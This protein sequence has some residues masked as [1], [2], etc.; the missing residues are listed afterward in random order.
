MESTTSQKFVTS[1]NIA[2]AEVVVL[3]GQDYEVKFTDV[4][5]NT[6]FSKLPEQKHPNTF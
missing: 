1:F 5:P 4:T 3:I 2:G 6:R